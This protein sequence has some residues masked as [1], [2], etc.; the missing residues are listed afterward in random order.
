MV[1]LQISKILRVTL[2]LSALAFV[3]VSGVLS[4]LVARVLVR[5]LEFRRRPPGTGIPCRRALS[6]PESSH[7]L[8]SCK[9]LLQ[10]QDTV[11]SKRRLRR[12]P[13]NSWSSARAGNLSIAI[14]RRTV[15][16]KSYY[17]DYS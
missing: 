10:V 15:A 7:R 9:P 6:T 5:T 13:L 8:V 17:Y 2:L 11:S 14:C 16:Q 12:T 1:L 4:R 3:A